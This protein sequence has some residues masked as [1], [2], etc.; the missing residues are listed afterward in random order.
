M[1]NYRK[2][3]VALVGLVVLAAG[4]YGFDL[5]GQEQMIVDTVVSVLTVF[6]IYQVPNS[7]AA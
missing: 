6:G 2:L 5:S 7:E 4:R 1:T 3:I